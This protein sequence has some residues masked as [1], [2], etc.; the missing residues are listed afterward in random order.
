MA[1]FTTRVTLHNVREDSEV[2]EE[3]HGNMK[4][5]G[6]ER[7]ISSDDETYHLPH[8]E[9]CYEG[10]VAKGDVLV[11]AKRAAEKTGKRYSVLVTKSAGRTWYGL[12]EVD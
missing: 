9:Y 12:E 7:T 1:K 5:E 11:K 6:F 2:Y 4:H 3:L 10:N 8:A